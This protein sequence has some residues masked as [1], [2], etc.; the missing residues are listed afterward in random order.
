LFVFSSRLFSILLL[1]LISTSHENSGVFP[2]GSHISMP[3]FSIYNE[4]KTGL[5]PYFSPMVEKD[6]VRLHGFSADHPMHIRFDA[7]AITRGE[8]NSFFSLFCAY[9]RC[10]QNI[11][12]MLLKEAFP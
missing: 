1:D 9:S 7:V 4:S 10:I 8:I 5:I 2:L 12:S 6:G 11:W 3:D